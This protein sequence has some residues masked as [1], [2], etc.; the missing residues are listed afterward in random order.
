MFYYFLVIILFLF[1]CVFS[2]FGGC[3]L[4]AH[5]ALLQRIMR[6]FCNN[7]KKSEPTK[8]EKICASKQVKW[9]YKK[10]FL[11]I[12]T[13][14]CFKGIFS[15]LYCYDCLLTSFFVL[16]WNRCAAYFKQKPKQKKEEAITENRN[17]TKNI[18]VYS[19][20]VVIGFFFAFFSLSTNIFSFYW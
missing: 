17:T 3:F 9:I 10:K 20:Y 8:Q 2:V 1:L 14:K 4:R 5:C 12:S 13:W 16:F 19:L 7:R 15:R 11:I 18:I 6:T